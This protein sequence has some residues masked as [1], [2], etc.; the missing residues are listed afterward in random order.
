MNYINRKKESELISS[1]VDYPVTAIIGARQTGKSTL[2]RYLMKQLNQYVYLD[3][4]NP[5]DLAKLQD[6]KAYFD[7]HSDK[8]IC[9]DEVQRKKELFPIIRSVVDR[10][11]RNGQFLI[12]GS[13]SPDLLRQSSESLAGRINYHELTPF[14]INELE[15]LST[16]QNYM[17][18]G[19]FPKSILARDDELSFDWRL[20]FIRTFLERDILNFGFDVPPEHMN[21][22]WK[23]LAHINGQLLN[24]SQLG[25]SLGVSH[26]TIKNHIEI[27]NKTYMIRILKPYHGNLKKRLIKTPKVYIK[28]PGIL[29]T[30]LN[31]HSFE[32]I[33]SHPVY[34]S[35]W[36]NI[37]TEHILHN[38]KYWEPFFYR[39]SNGNEIDLIL[40][41]GTKKIA[42]ECKNT[43][44]PK[45]S[46]GFYAAISEL[47]IDK[48]FIAAPVNEEYPVKNDVMVTPLDV[49]MTH[50]SKL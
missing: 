49:L 10:T 33:F 16:L 25:N 37:V 1:L 20:N 4:E 38:T 5:E 39:T 13:A 2:A 22:L 34:G 41:K 17:N 6:P 45:V 3:L 27:L 44:S 35:V 23:M 18:R 12:L 42:I 7:L 40:M 48:A 43:S 36:E 14:L 19:G 8:T 29:N 32:D 47:E 28:D 26:T 15:Q 24:Y 50:I 9:I 46:Q 31:L 21:R 30:L 11:G